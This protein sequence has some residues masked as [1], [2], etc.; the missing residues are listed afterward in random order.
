MLEEFKKDQ[1]IQKYGAKAF[2]CRKY[3]IFQSTLSVVLNGK[4][5]NSKI[6]QIIS[7]YLNL[8]EEEKDAFF[9][10]FIEEKRKNSPPRSKLKSSNP[11]LDT[12]FSGVTLTKDAESRIS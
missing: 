4:Q 7:D 3:D 11:L 1:R 8:S 10:D 6:L 9:Q 5:K 2:F 12:D